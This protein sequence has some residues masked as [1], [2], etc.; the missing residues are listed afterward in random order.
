MCS[1]K[2]VCEVRGK[3]SEVVKIGA[4]M[5]CP[6]L[7]ASLFILLAS[8]SVAGVQERVMCVCDKRDERC[9]K[10]GMT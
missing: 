9:I 1:A 4:D 5:I 8:F 2:R 10:R 3:G 6:S 7:F